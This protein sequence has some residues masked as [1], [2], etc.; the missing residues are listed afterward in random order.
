LIIL[1]QEIDD[2]T[3]DGSNFKVN[4]RF[5]PAKGG[6][7]ATRPPRFL[8]RMM[9]NISTNKPHISYRR[10]VG[11]GVCRDNCAGDAIKIEKR[12]ATIDYTKCIRC[13]CCHELCPHN[14][15]YMTI[16]E[17]GLANWVGDTMYKLYGTVRN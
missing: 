1:D 6:A 10:C 9:I 11:C 13:Y 14:A 15:V 16:R 5:K 3:G 12:K 4:P 17:S 2:L 7:I 8:K